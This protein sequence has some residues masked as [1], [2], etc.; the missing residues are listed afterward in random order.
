MTNYA[1]IY[2]LSQLDGKLE[3]FELNNYFWKDHFL[4]S[5]HGIIANLLEQ[6]MVELN[7][8]REIGLSKLYVD[9]LKQILN[10]QKLSTT[11]RKKILIQRIVKCVPDEEIQKHLKS[12]VYFVT[13]KGSKLLEQN[14]FVPTIIQH[15]TD[16][17]ITFKTAELAKVTPETANSLEI[18]RQITDHVIDQC[19]INHDYSR[20]YETLCTRYG[21]LANYDITIAE[22][23]QTALKII[24]LSLSGQSENYRQQSIQQL[25]A[26]TH[27]IDDL[28]YFIV[29]YPNAFIT[30]IIRLMNTLETSDEEIIQ[31]FQEIQS[32]FKD[33]ES[34]CSN[35]EM[36]MIL[37][38]GL[39]ND[40]SKLEQ[41]Y[42]QKLLSIKSKK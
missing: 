31:M 30:K 8:E 27:D 1:E 18:I 6:G 14:A 32:E 40:W 39:D 2:A 7:Y 17:I 11:G 28:K 25:T 33:I 9:E 36:I 37:Q 15:Y 42:Q 24:Y 10:S 12:R 22:M 35:Q 19:Q 16:N 21:A 29:P 41:I 34:I 23:L 26:A 20:L 4:T 5:T 13:D 3:S 38:A